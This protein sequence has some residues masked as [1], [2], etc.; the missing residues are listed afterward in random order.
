MSVRDVLDKY[1]SKISSE[2]GDESGIGESYSRDYM[3]FRDDMS[4]ELSR[5]ERWCHS[6]GS[7]I[8][9]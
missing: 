4:P 3:Q 6:L 7:F 2:M 5:Y 8:K 9:L 1:E